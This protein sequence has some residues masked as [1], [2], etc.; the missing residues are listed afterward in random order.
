MSAN[1]VILLGMGGC[2][3]SQLA[4]EYCEQAELKN[5]FSAVFWVDALSPATVAQSYTAIAKVVGNSKIDATDTEGNIS[6]VLETLATWTMRW[7][8]VF[9]NFD[10]PEAFD[11]RPI[12]EYFPR[13]RYGSVLITSRCIA[14]KSLGHAISVSDMKE[15][16]ALDL[17]FRRSQFE[18]NEMSVSKAKKI[19]NRLGYLALA[20]DQAGAYIAARNIN[21]DQFMDHFNRR[22]EVVLKETPNLWD[23]R[24]KK[25]ETEAEQSMTV[26]T[27]W[28]LSFEQ[29]TEDNEIPGGRRHFFLLVA[30]FD[31]RKISEELFHAF[32]N[33]DAPSWM[34]IFSDESSWDPFKFLDIVAELQRLSLIQITDSTLGFNSFSVHPVIQDW[35]KMRLR[36]SDRQEYTTEAIQILSQFLSTHNHEAM[37]LDTKLSTVSHIDNA[38]EN[39]GQ[40]L[41]QGNRLG[42]VVLAQPTC[43]FADFLRSQGQYDQAEIL[44]NS[45][46]TSLKGQ[47][48]PRHLRTLLIMED[49]GIVYSEKGQYSQAEA[50][51]QQVLAKRKEEL[52]PK[53]LLTLRA[54]THLGTVY[55]RQ[56]QYSESEP[57][58][59]QALAEYKE[60]LGSKH[61]STLLGMQNLASVY[62]AQQRHS[63]AEGLYL[64]VVAEYKDQ[65]GPTHLKTLQA[66]E[67]LSILYSWQQQASKAEG[68]LTQVL[69]EYMKQLGSE[70]PRTLTT[71]DTLAIC[72]SEQGQHM[73]A[74][75]CYEQSHAGLEKRLGPYH[76]KTLHVLHNLA[77][78]SDSLHKEQLYRQALAGRIK[79]LGPEHQDTLRT[80]HSL[81]SFYYNQHQYSKAE[82]IYEQALT[83]RE[84]QLGRQHKDTIETMHNLANVY[85]NQDQFEKA[86]P[87][88]EQVLAGRERELGLEHHDTLH[89]VFNLACTYHKLRQYNKAEPLFK[90]ALAGRG[91]QLGSKHPY[92]RLIVMC[93]VECRSLT[94]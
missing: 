1:V 76:Q 42:E 90:R 87:L 59:K 4:L 25:D 36:P 23:Y 91:K 38:L 51:F 81:G 27:T 79:Q 62:I 24:R 34:N 74:R 72:Y 49:L 16:E 14:S 73:K 94:S 47:L 67:N 86:Y 43:N 82:P 75:L 41:V 64:Q 55:Y 8:L 35:A 19:V 21:L 78:S 77:T 9:D 89:T 45:L 46:L 20:V 84:K 66:M 57:L 65:L 6:I 37:D 88:F 28:E 80:L 54:M 10:K 40:Y 13:N 56:Q 68:I 69:T 29:I 33:A 5:D 2:G 61:D 71:L 26:A 58:T 32:F 7:L 53:D 39:D 92:T 18:R 48:G 12:R 3:K 85:H 60:Q 50:L 44:Y 70:H 22:R 83:G 17:L 30:F 11:K 31:G 93:L 15:D 52:G 63:E